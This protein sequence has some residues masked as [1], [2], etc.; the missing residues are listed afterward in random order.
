MYYDIL[1]CTINPVRKNRR[2]ND[3]ETGFSSYGCR[4][5]KPLRR[6]KTD[7]SDWQRRPYH[8]GFF[9]LWCSESRIWKSCIYYK[10]RKWR[11]VPWS[12]RRPSE[13]TD[14]GCL[15]IPGAYKYSGGIF[16]TGRQS[17]AMG[18]RTCGIK[19]YWWDRWTICRNQCRWLLR[20]TCI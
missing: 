2:K 12:N 15:C 8:H 20:C 5:G 19:L 16:C 17:K 11:S 7:R 18:Y 9:Y 3:E 13:Q 14:R 10:E 4:N 6:I 1:G